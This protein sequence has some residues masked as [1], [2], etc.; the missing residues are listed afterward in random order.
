MDIEQL[1]K[2]GPSLT[3][4]PEETFDD[5]LVQETEKQ[6]PAE[7]VYDEEKY[8]TKKKK[9]QVE[10][11]TEQIS[12]TDSAAILQYGSGIQKKMSD[13][14]EGTLNKVRN[15]DLGEIGE[16]LGGVV[17][18]LKEFD[19]E[20]SRGVLGFFKKKLAKA[21]ALKKRDFTPTSTN[22]FMEKDMNMA[23]TIAHEKGLSL[24]CTALCD[25]M[26]NGMIG[27]GE[28]DLD[29]YSLLLLNEEMN[30]MAKSDLR[31]RGG[32]SRQL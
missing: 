2:E 8:L 24:P 20:E 18:E 17:K 28:G 9:K 4:N 23:M 15:K 19:E 3:L 26:Y 6:T 21:E 32:G 22:R 1:L 12:L 16:L 30:G 29:Y 11:F 5:L 27:R 10:E 13:F 31:R 14:S 25:Q 7:K